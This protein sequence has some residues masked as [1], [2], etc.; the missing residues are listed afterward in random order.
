MMNRASLTNYSPKNLAIHGIPVN[1]ERT[2]QSNTF[3]NSRFFPE[4]NPSS[5]QT[6]Q[7]FSDHIQLYRKYI[8]DLDNYKLLKPIKIT[9]EYDDDYYLA[10][11]DDFPFYITGNTIEEAKQNLIYDIEETYEEFCDEPPTTPDW[12]K[13]LNQLNDIIVHERRKI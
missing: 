7:I 8:F 5:T 10:S 4:F 11:T 1:P 9:I 6:T 2:K 3:K 12:K 13:Y